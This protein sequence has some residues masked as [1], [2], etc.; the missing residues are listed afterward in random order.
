MNID[1]RAI[2]LPVVVTTRMIERLFYYSWQRRRLGGRRS[3]RLSQNLMDFCMLDARASDQVVARRRGF[4]YPDILYHIRERT[5]R[6]MNEDEQG[7]GER[8]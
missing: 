3:Q 7:S 4:Q 1:S 6:R 2:L 8:T 5:I